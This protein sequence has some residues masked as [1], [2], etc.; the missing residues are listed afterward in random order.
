MKSRSTA[1]LLTLAVIL[2]VAPI[3]AFTGNARL[4]WQLPTANTDASAIP[5][6]GTLALASIRVEYFQC[7]SATVT[8]PA[9]PTVLSVPVPATSYTVTGLPEGQTFCF[10]I[11][12]VN[13]AGTL[14]AP[15]AVQTKLIPVTV[16]SPPVLLTIETVAY[17]V[18]TDWP[19]LT[20]KRSKV[21]GTV[22][23]GVACASPSVDGGA[24][25]LIPR[26]AVTW[27]GTSRPSYV[28][29]KCA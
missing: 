5:A 22:A 11:F 18:T 17:S 23:L 8:W 9:T 2:L 13:N 4:T 10:R 6:T 21:V 27:T 16:P 3:M 28:V 14:S 15:S 25:R 26:T 7:A 29:A 12:A 20:F 1:Y 19:A 24:Y